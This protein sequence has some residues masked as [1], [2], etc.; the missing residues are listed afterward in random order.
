MMYKLD[1]MLKTIMNKAEAII[2]CTQ[3][4]SK[5]FDIHK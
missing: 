4:L 3:V 5:K 1:I 2:A